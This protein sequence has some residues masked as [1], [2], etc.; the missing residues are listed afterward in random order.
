MWSIAIQ[1]IKRWLRLSLARWGSRLYSLWDGLDPTQIITI[2]SITF[3]ER[4]NVCMEWPTHRRAKRRLYCH[5]LDKHCHYSEI[6]QKLDFII[7]IFSHIYKACGVKMNIPS[8]VEVYLN[9]WNMRIKL[10][11]HS[12]MSFRLSN[13]WRIKWC[14]SFFSYTQG[15]SGLYWPHLSVVQNITVWMRSLSVL[16][17]YWWPSWAKK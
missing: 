16:T 1:G 8:Y 15:T 3:L 13:L 5:L 14:V 6:T 7:C 2:Q 10:K 4:Y 11:T 9:K 12:V 17:L